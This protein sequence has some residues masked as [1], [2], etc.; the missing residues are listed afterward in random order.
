MEKMKKNI[1]RTNEAHSFPPFALK[2][3]H[4]HHFWSI[5]ISETLVNRLR[6]EVSQSQKQAHLTPSTPRTNIH[7]ITPS[8]SYTSHPVHFT[9]ASLVNQ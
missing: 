5:P 6:H 7:S 4:L 8:L 3:I 9:Q 1:S 2:N